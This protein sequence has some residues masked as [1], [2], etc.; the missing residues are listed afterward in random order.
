MKKLRACLQF[1]IIVG[2]LSGM[3]VGGAWRFQHSYPTAKWA[4]QGVPVWD[5]I[6]QTASWYFEGFLSAA[7]IGFF[8]GLLLYQFAPSDEWLHADPTGARAK[9][10]DRA[11]KILAT[12]LILG[13]IAHYLLVVNHVL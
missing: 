4:A 12:L 9:K 2:L 6:V 11:G 5:R 1:S 8:L 13:L 7:T 10:V 3:V